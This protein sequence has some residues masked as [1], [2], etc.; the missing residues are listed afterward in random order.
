MLQGVKHRDASGEVLYAI[1]VLCWVTKRH[2]VMGC[3]SLGV[4]VL[5]TNFHWAFG[6][7]NANGFLPQEISLAF[8]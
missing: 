7:R 1:I 8:R 5:P 6:E 3:Y 2:Q 4:I